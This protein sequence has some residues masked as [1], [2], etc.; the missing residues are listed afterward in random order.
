MCKIIK[1][2]VDK[3]PEHCILCPLQD[4]PNCFYDNI[5]RYECG[6]NGVPDSRCLLEITENKR[7]S[8]NEH[9]EV[10]SSIGWEEIEKLQ[11]GIDNV[12]T[13]VSKIPRKKY[14]TEE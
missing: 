11:K 5:I 3:L 7:D 13:K 12:F 1:A 10:Y 8:K 6:E 4:I 9:E 14:F 2:F